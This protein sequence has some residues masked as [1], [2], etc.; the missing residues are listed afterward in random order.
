MTS[1][2]VFYHGNCPDGFTAALV[3]Y[4]VLREKAQYVACFY[5][6]ENWSQIDVENK[7]VYILDFHFNEDVLKEFENKTKS[8]VLLDHHMTAKNKLKDFCLHCK[9][10]SFL[11]FDLEKSGASLAWEYFYPGKKTPFLIEL[12]QDRDLYTWKIKNARDFCSA[13]ELINYEFEKWEPLLYLNTEEQWDYFLQ[14]GKTINEY[15]Q[16]L[17]LDSLGSA[18]EIEIFGFKGVMLNLNSALLKS[19]TGEIL[20]N[21]FPNSLFSMTYHLTTDNKVACSLRTKGFDARQNIAEKLKGGGHPQACGLELT[22]E[23]LVELQLNRKL[24]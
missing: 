9:K 18:V 22:L 7:D 8:L 19:N 24:L 12:I 16:R 1:A 6:K 17:I 2:V 15:R 11:K 10:S 20:L 21:K 3:A 14:Q 13:L 4:T 23:Q 5:E